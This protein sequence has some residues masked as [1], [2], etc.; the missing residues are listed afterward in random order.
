M[1]TTAPPRS[2]SVTC[3]GSPSAPKRALLIHGLMSSSGCWFRVAQAL[4]N[5]GYF[6]T[7]PDLLGHGTAPRS[8]DCSL[9]TL[10]AALHPLFDATRPFSIIV[11]H[12]FGGV[13]AL[14]LLSILPTTHITPVLLLD[15]PILP[16][17]QTPAHKQSMQ[18]TERICAVVVEEVTSKIPTVDGLMSANPKWSREDA[19]WKVLGAQL[20]D[21]AAIEA[22]FRQN[23]PWSFEH[24]L[25]IIPANVRLS[26]I[27]GDPAMHPAFFVDTAEAFPHI[28]TTSV[29]GATHSIHREFPE[30]VSAAALAAVAEVEGLS[31]RV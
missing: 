9:A 1:A 5:E 17:D 14:A 16:P 18:R 26:I 20:C 4:A 27:A 11:G 22:I 25:E 19:V 10:A 2:L 12:S 28:R 23:F 8:A 24:L 15:P 21:P 13:V 31:S 3:W 29:E 6:V 30:V 7:A